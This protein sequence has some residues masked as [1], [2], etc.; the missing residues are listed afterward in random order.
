[1]ENT[2]TN[3]MY[4]GATGTT[5]GTYPSTSSA[6]TPYCSCNKESFFAYNWE[7]MVEA[8]LKIINKSGQDHYKI[9]AQNL[10]HLLLEAGIKAVE[11]NSALKD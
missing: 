10:L 6:I 2:N 4:V 3:A 9:R 5:I 11:N 1:M 7:S 8:T